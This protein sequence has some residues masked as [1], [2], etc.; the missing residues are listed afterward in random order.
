VSHAQTARP[1]GSTAP[2]ARDPRDL[3]AHALKVQRGDILVVG[4]AGS[5]AAPSGGRRA[6]RRRHRRHTSAS[7]STRATRRAAAPPM[8]W[9]ITRP[10]TCRASTTSRAGHRHP[11]ITLPRWVTSGA[12]EVGS[13]SPPCSG[14]STNLTAGGFAEAKV[15]TTRNRLLTGGCGGA[16][17]PGAGSTRPPDARTRRRDRPKMGSDRGAWDGTASVRAFAGWTPLHRLWRPATFGRV[18]GGTAPWPSSDGTASTASSTS[19]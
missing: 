8:A 9:S 12:C 11:T 10:A 13:N 3:A 19:C 5:R 17:L 4:G 2:H 1:P 14:P 16:E 15:N 7:S 6:R 18:K